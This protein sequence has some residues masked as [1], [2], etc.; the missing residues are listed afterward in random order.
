MIYRKCFRKD[1][2]LIINTNTS[3]N[4]NNEDKETRKLHLNDNL[5][6]DENKIVFTFKDNFITILVKDNFQFQIANVIFKNYELHH[7][8]N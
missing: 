5:K 3:T 6:L 7:S 1:L 2:N 4:T 8:L